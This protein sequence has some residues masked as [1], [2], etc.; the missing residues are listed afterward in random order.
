MTYGFICNHSLG[1]ERVKSQIKFVK[2][3]SYIKGKYFL[4]PKRLVQA[5]GKLSSCIFDKNRS[6]VVK[7]EYRQLIPKTVHLE[8]CA[9][10]TTNLSLL[11]RKQV[12]IMPHVQFRIPNL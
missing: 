9:V 11:Y 1:F 2:R 4:I 8:E 5:H 10:S 12:A 3:K 6:D 7:S